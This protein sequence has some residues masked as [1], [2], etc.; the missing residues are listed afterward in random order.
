MSEIQKPGFSSPYENLLSISTEEKSLSIPA[1]EKPLSISAAEKPLSI[2]AVEKPLSIP[3]AEKPLSILAA[4]KPLSISTAAIFSSVPTAVYC[5]VSTLHPHQQDSLENQIRHYQEFMKKT[6]NYILTE[7]Y[8]DFGISGYKETRPGFCKMLEDA[9]KGCFRQIITKSITRFARNTDTVLKTTRQLKELGI[10]IYFELQKIHTLSQEGELL[11][12]LFAA[13]A[14]EE[15]EN[16]RWLTKMAIQQKYRKGHPMRQL[17]RCLGYQKDQAGNLIPDKNAEL[18]RRIFQM[19]ADGW[20]ISQITKY[21][22]G[23]KIT[24]QND[25]SFSRSTVSRILHNHAYKGDYICQ[26]YY[27]NNQRKLVRNKGEKQMYYIRHDHQAIVSEELWETAQEKLA[28]KSERNRQGIPSDEIAVTEKVQVPDMPEKRTLKET[29]LQ[30][31]KSGLIP[32]KPPL[33]LTNYPYK[34]R[35]FCKYCGSRLRRIIARNHSV[36]W[37]CNGLSRKGKAFCKGVRIPDEKLSPLRN[38]SFSAY[39][40][41]EL[42]D[43]KETYGYSPKPDEWKR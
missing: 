41:K 37:I 34:D 4:E 33:T 30:K 5:R 19:A 10:D 22:N 6:Q 16:A 38:I 24:T 25:R 42:I 18:V 31:E 43:G 15:S 20:S 14:Q 1:V 7:I 21:L 3:A 32:V 23:N 29:I 12:T 35:I 8:Y 9:R 17:H 2:P 39:I 36:W 26:R 11:L 13:F 40:G 27:V 28:K